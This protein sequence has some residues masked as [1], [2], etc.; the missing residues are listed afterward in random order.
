[1]PVVV[2]R[3]QEFNECNDYQLELVRELDEMG[4][5]LAVYD[6][7][8]LEQAINKARN[9]VSEHITENRIP[10]IIDDFLKKNLGS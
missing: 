5:I 2:P 9:F 4:K 1:M 6:I 3:Q 10:S 7:A 8:A